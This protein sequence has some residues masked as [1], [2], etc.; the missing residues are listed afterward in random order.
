MPARHRPGLLRCEPSVAEL[1]LT[2][3]YPLKDTDLI[4]AKLERSSS[5]IAV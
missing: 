3:T 2:G 1:R 5:G 4:L